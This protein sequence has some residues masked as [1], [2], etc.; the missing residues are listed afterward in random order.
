MKFKNFI[1][2][3]LTFLIIGCDGSYKSNDDEMLYEMDPFLKSGGFIAVGNS[4]SI[5]TSPD[6]TLWTETERSPNI[7]LM[8]VYYRSSTYL[9]VGASNQSVIYSSGLN[10]NT[11]IWK[12]RFLNEDSSFALEGIFHG[13]DMFVAVGNS[14][15]ILASSDGTSWSSR[16][17]GTSNQLNSITYG[18]SAFVAV[19]G[20][21]TILTSLDNTSWSSRTSGTSNQ[22]NSITYGGSTFVAVGSSG[23]ILTSLDN[24]S[25][26]SRTSG[27]S[28]QLNSITYGDS[29]FVAVG[30]NG[31]IL[32]S[33]DGISWTSRT[34][35]T[36]NQLNSI[37]YRGST[38]F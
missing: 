12:Q 14:G 27:T 4:G 34:S 6:G 38:Q 32:T 23:T 11:G 36:S 18:D 15:T 5:L 8:D 24:T 1:F 25:W 28:N 3:I 35:G 29:A 7:N 31:T 26:S 10:I 33:S 9:V 22:L 2:F 37:I 21:G 30:G 13:I 17:S 16:T 19:G 20:N